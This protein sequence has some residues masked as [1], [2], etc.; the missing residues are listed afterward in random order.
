MAKINAAVREDVRHGKLSLKDVPK[1]GF[2]AILLKKGTKYQANAFTIGS[3]HLFITEEMNTLLTDHWKDSQ[4]FLKGKSF[5][6]ATITLV[7]HYI[8]GLA[9]FNFNLRMVLV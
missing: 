5:G 3:G 1:A 2:Q 6:L 4:I 7:D 9:I 8:H